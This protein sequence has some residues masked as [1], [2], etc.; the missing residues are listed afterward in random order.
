MAKFWRQ[1]DKRQMAA[2][3]NVENEVFLKTA[4]EQL[5]ELAKKGLSIP[6][7]TL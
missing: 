6:V 4:Q 7:F 3:T 1:A 5:R 2:K